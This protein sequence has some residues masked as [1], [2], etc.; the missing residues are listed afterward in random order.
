MS[1]LTATLRRH[2]GLMGYTALNYLDKFFSFAVPLLVLY[3]FD[4]KG[5]YNEIEYVYSIGAVAAVVIE[6]GVRN[7][8][9]YAYKEAT[10]RD[11]LVEM[12]RGNFLLQ[13]VLYLAIGLV[14]LGVSFVSGGAVTPIYF[15]IVVRALFMYFVSF[16]TI[17]YR[18]VDKPSKVFLFSLGVNA[19]TIALLLFCAETLGRIDLGY[20]FAGQ[21]GLVILAGL[22]G[23]RARVWE[24]FRGFRFYVRRAMKFAWPII[25]NVLLILF[26]M[27][28]GKVY[29]RNFLS[30]EDMYHLSLVQR[31]SLVIQL[32]HVSAI[33]YFSK[34][35]F[36]GR[37]LGF[38]RAVFRLYGI[39]V[40]ASVIGVVGIL[41][42]LPLVRP[43]L[44]VGV[45][46]VSMLLIAFMTMWCLSSFGELYVNKLNRNKVLPLFSCVAAAVFC[47]FQILPFATSLLSISLAMATSMACYLLSV[48]A[49]LRKS[50]SP[51]RIE[52]LKVKECPHASVR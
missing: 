20:F 52:G 26:L 25:L 33:G 7:Y 45:D 39:M 22:Y 34:R 51:N 3:L 6:L 30:Q 37:D 8:F 16:F 2:S 24:H 14:I 41:L 11:S 18:L 28:Y 35:V 15:F 5:I 40:G 10:D 29:A 43:R 27:N 48:I 17:Y 47:V 42:V 46:A 23:A 49:F 36:I 31:L 12:V 50:L 4:D 1:A 9:L 38:D 21:I 13:F 32:T 44:G 19:G